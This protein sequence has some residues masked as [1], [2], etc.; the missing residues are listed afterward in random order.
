MQPKVSEL[1]SPGLKGGNGIEDDI[2]SIRQ[3]L[4]GGFP[5]GDKVDGKE[6]D[7]PAHAW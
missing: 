2:D 4:T 7:K 6:A 1:H 3:S 5:A